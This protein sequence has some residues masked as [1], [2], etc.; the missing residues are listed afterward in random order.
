VLG[1]AAGLGSHSLTVNDGQHLPG[2][3]SPA[4]TC[5]ELADAV[6]SLSQAASSGTRPAGSNF[7]TAAI[8]AEPGTATIGTGLAPMDSKAA[9][10]YSYWSPGDLASS[11][12]ANAMQLYF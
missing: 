11:N 2:S 5:S 7:A 12:V 10:T 6:S 9:P 8:A 1:A 4:L 3:G